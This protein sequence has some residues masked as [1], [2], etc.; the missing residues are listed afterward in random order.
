MPCDFKLHPPAIGLVGEHDRRARWRMRA[1]FVSH[2]K[3][4]H[5]VEVPPNWGYERIEEEHDVLR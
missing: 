5:Q 1:R 4:V 2:M 3:A